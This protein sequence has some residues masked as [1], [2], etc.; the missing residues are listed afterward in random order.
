MRQLSES[1]GYG[2][3]PAQTGAGAFERFSLP[4]ASGAYRWFY[5]DAVCGELTAVAIFLI[6]SVFSPRYSAGLRRGALP[7]S[8]CAVNFAL[9]RAGR[10][11]LW[12]LTEYDRLQQRR[13]GL[14]FGA[15]SVEF[16]SDGGARFSVRERTA[17]W[18]RPVQAELELLPSVPA[19]RERALGV[20]Q[21][22]YWQ[23]LAAR[24]EA[25]LLLRS[26]GLSLDVS[27]HGYLD[28]NRGERRLGDELARWQWQRTH[29]AER[30]EVEYVTPGSGCLR[31]VAAG[32]R[33]ELLHSPYSAVEE[34]RR[35]RWGLEVPAR[36]QLL[37]SSPFYA[38]WERRRGEEHTLGEVAD[39]ARF[40]RPSIRWMAHFRTRRGAR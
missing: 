4:V 21:P 40:H 10:P 32:A 28:T 29:Q 17:P 30:T 23:P 24:A 37:E 33:C 6:G 5:A 35:S 12:V 20:G 16:L 38:R 2:P 8:H 27:G 15:S 18:G 34:V 39:F 14:T 25:R 36:E 22:H 9:Y 19:V 11:L 7:Q 1:G 3:V 26:R 31:L 13:D